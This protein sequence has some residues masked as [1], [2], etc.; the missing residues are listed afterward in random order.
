MI[1]KNLKIALVFDWM[2]TRGGAER[3]NLH[4]AQIFPNADIFTSVINFKKFPELKTRNV[5]SSFLQK[6]PFAKSKHQLFLSLMP[7]AYEGFDLSQYDLVIS[8]SHSCAKGIITKPETLHICYCHAPMR[9]A[10]NDWHKYI[11]EY[12]LPSFIKSIGKKMI[13]KIRMW[14]K[15]SADRPDFYFANSLCTQNR[16]RKYYRKNSEILYP[17]INTKSFNLSNVTEDYFLAV[18]R[19]T[20]YKRFD[21]LVETFN[22][23]K[24]PLKIVG[25]GVEEEA[26]KKS[27]KGNIKFLGYVSEKKLRQLYQNCKALVFPQLEDFGITPL[28]V[29]AS[30]K[31]VIAYKAG[32]AL[33]TV[34]ENKTGVFFKEQTHESLNQ[35]ITEFQ[36]QKFNNLEIRKHAEKF[37]QQKFKEK[38]LTQ[39]AKLMQK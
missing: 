23:N 26:L 7:Y 9:Y 20:P 27:A 25:T 33:E 17:S 10:W 24:L 32:G 8:S 16:I 28:E 5:T 13:H 34:I 2:T 1:N 3:V 35:A 30:G 4:L 29:M 18:G 11:N 22:K 39:I 36:K 15:I 37:D 19:L 31:P 6:I 12:K 21:L 14:D 38:L